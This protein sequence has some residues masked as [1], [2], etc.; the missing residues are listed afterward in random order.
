MRFLA[1]LI[2]SALGFAANAVYLGQA[3]AGANDGSSCAN[4][5]AYTYFN[6][7]GN[8]NASPTGIQIGPDSTVH[9]CGSITGTGGSGATVFVFQGSGTSGHPVTMLWETGAGLTA[10]YFSLAIDLGTKTNIVLDGGTACGTNAGGS[11]SGVPS[12]NGTIQNTANGTSL[13]NQSH[14]TFIAASSM[15]HCT[16]CVVK[17]L[18]LYNNYVHV[19]C[20]ASS[21]CDGS[22]GTTENAVI[23]FNGGGAG[24][25][26]KDN[27]IHDCSWCVNMQAAS[28][29]TN[30]TYQNNYE[31]AVAH[32]LAIYGGFGWPGPAIVRNNY[33]GDMANWDT[34]TLDAYHADGIHAFG[35]DLSEIDIYNNQFFTQNQCCITGEIFL[36]GS[37][38]NT[39]TVSGVYYIFNNIFQQPSGSV[40]GLVQVYLGAADRFLN[41]TI[42]GPSGGSTNTCLY[43]SGS[44]VLFQNN[45]VSGCPN[46]FNMNPNVG[47]TFS[48]VAT[49]LDYQ[50]YG[51]TSGFN[52]F[53]FSAADTGS[54]TTWKASG[55]CG[56]CDTHSQS[57]AD[58]HLNANGT[59]TVS[60][61]SIVGQGKNLTALCSGSLTALCSD[62]FGTA[63]P[64]S[65][66][67][68]IGAAQLSGTPHGGSSRGGPLRIGGPTNQN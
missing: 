34:G 58:Q 43:M 33:F 15:G 4:Q 38:G 64:S 41:N 45:V 1:Y 25:V 30:F 67:W 2:F 57:V 23:T 65:G 55:S 52:S 42:V 29:D 50:S 28:G 39:W 40:N 68:D 9:L 31:T 44:T 10:T 56:G 59:P 62:M 5:K 51:P 6:S 20:E 17:N 37:M 47:T 16:N 63:R 8:W 14:S 3:S 53:V 13:A 11:T 60:S 48:T 22:A 26:I 24:I 18:G 12:C 66:S 32:G 46:L 7:A 54:F 61:T 35:M 19:Q 36:E 27:N 21:G 49:D